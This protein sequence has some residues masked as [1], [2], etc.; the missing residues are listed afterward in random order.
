MVKEM[1]V[2]IEYYA[3]VCQLHAKFVL[4]KLCVFSVS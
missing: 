3:S 2:G 1:L 4:F